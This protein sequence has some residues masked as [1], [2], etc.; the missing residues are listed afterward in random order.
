MR[1]PR[2]A[3]SAIPLPY[4]LFLLYIEPVSALLGA[5][6]AYAT[7]S[8]YLRLTHLA[9][10]P[11]SATDPPLATAIALRQLANLYLLFAVAEALVLRAA[12]HDRSVWRAMLTALLVA[13]LGHLWSVR[14]LGW[15]VYFRFWDWNEMMWGNL[16]FVYVGAAVRIAFLTGVGGV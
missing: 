14:E 11:V 4:R 6:V 3:A 8:Y 7:P 15:D 12:G 9:S 5:Y 1:Q 2:S 16:G 10:A 13:D